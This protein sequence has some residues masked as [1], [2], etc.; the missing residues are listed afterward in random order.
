MPDSIPLI[1]QIVRHP[2]GPVSVMGQRTQDT[3]GVEINKLA[4]RLR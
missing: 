3:A 2:P 4:K 1:H